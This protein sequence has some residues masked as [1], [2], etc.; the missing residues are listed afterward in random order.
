MG[1]LKSPS[2]LWEEGALHMG[3]EWAKFYCPNRPPVTTAD[4]NEDELSNYRTSDQFCRAQV[5]FTSVKS[6]F[7]RS[8]S[9]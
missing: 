1:L 3:E 2:G 7:H 6:L 4:L 9:V 5:F 8:L